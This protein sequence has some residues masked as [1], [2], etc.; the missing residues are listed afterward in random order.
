MPMPRMAVGSHGKITVEPRVGRPGYRARTRVCGLDGI[1]RPL[2]RSGPTQQAALDNLYK[3]IKEATSVIGFARTET[4]LTPQTSMADL[5]ATWAETLE[6]S[7]RSSGTEWRYKCAVRQLI[8]EMG[9][10]ALAE[11]SP[12]VMRG[13]LRKV[14]IDDGHPSKAAMHRTVLK[15]ALDLAVAEDIMG[16]N[17]V[18][19][20]S[21]ELAGTSK[22]RRKVAVQAPS[23]ADV[24]RMLLLAEEDYLERLANHHGGLKPTRDFVDIL[25][26]VAGLGC[27]TGEAL[28]I[29]RAQISPKGFVKIDGTIVMNKEKRSLER[30][31]ATKSL[32]GERILRAP[33]W[34]MEIFRR[35][36]ADNDSPMLFTS[37]S[38]DFYNVD[39]AG[40]QLRD[41]KARHGIEGFTYRSLR[42]AVATA[43]ASELGAGAAR[44]HLGHSDQ[45]VTESYYIQ[46]ET[47]YGPD[48]RDLLDE[49]DPSRPAVGENENKLNELAWDDGKE[50][51]SEDPDWGGQL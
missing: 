35:R 16:N 21:P 40:S 3:A 30:Q 29:G 1:V 27:R 44:D 33:E 48:A 6:N 43:I 41:F 24:H 45:K 46:A 14:A 10:L 18:S 47:P 26:V 51:K 32:A 12:S 20:V 2:E 39:T 38:G 22:R 50:P 37:R 13:Y 4:G 25:G 8:S 34:T 23:L 7:G 9:V 5:L 42:K 19:V 49:L 36:L 11:I 15:Q 28:A 17:P 31:G